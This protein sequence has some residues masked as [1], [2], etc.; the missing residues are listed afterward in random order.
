M[1]KNKELKLGLPFITKKTQEAEEMT[2][3]KIELILS[4]LD[5]LPFNDCDYILK[6]ITHQLQTKMFTFKYK[7]GI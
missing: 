2:Q 5:G 3:L 1:G 6:E 7:R 4:E